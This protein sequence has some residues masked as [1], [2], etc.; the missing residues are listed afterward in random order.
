MSLPFRGE[1]ISQIPGVRLLMALELRG[2]SEQQ[3][4]LAGG[5]LPWLKQ[6]AIEGAKD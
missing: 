3:L 5:A 6:N 1:L 4:L 2:N